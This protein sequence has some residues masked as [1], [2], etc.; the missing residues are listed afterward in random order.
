MRKLLALA[1]A[2]FAVAVG[3]VVAQ[4]NSDRNYPYDVERA[5]RLERLERR[6]QDL[7]RYGWSDIGPDLQDNWQSRQQPYRARWREY[8]YGG[9]PWEC[10]N[11]RART[12]EAVRP[13]EYQD[14]LDYDRCRPARGWRR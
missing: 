2:P 3:P 14:D 13:G 10:F 5:Q 12:Y 4:D 8:A 11:F 9:R 6:E 1:L 7:R